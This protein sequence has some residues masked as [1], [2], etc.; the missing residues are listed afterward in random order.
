MSR[1]V[2]ALVLFLALSAAGT[3]EPASAP[4]SKEQV[5]FTAADQAAPAVQGA[6][7]N[8]SQAV[9]NVTNGEP[10]RDVAPH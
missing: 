8:A 3:A 1:A 6:A 9:Q 4:P 10:G 2:L 5:R 7:A